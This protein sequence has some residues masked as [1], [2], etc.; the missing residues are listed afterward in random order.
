[1]LPHKKPGNTCGVDKLWHEMKREYPDH[2]EIIADPEQGWAGI[3]IIP[4]A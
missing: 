4:V 1:V 2:Q 3:G